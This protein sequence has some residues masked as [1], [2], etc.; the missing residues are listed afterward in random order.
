MASYASPTSLHCL[1]ILLGFNLYARLASAQSDDGG[2]AGGVEPGDIGSGSDPQDSADAGAAGPDTGSVNLSRGATVAIA[3]VV[4]I[5]VVLGITLAVLYFLAK[6]KQWKI[7]EGLRRSVRRVGSAVKAVTSPMTPKMM[8]FPRA[9]KN[10]YPDNSGD[11]SQKTDTR[12]EAGP[13]SYSSRSNRV[14]DAEKGLPA[15]AIRVETSETDSVKNQRKDGSRPRPPKVNIPSSS[16]EM[17]SP[18]TP[19]WKKV[20]G[21]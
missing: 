5:V 2:A 21:R 11:R 3:V 14:Y 7:K 6:K 15:S 17:D 9:T 1:A 13:R 16:F 8:S 4:S 20:F 12:L 18:K 19:M 10:R